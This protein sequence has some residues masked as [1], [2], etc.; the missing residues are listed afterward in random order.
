M[1]IS[2]ESVKRSER[3]AWLR[4]YGTHAPLC[5]FPRRC[6]MAQPDRPLRADAARNRARVLEVAYDTFAAEGLVG[7]DRRDRP[8]RRRRRRAP[9]TGTSRPRRSC[10]GGHRG[11]DRA[12]SSTTAAALLASD[13]PGEA[14]FT[15]LRSMVLQWGGDRSRPGRR[16]RRGRH[17]HRDRA[18]DAEEAFL[19]LLGDLLR[20]GAEGGHGTA[21][22]RRAG[23]E[24]DP[25]RMPGDAGVQPR[26]GRAGDRGRHRRPYVRAALT[27]ADLALA[28]VE[29]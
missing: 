16:A 29:C 7:A 4:L 28:M 8:A 3:S 1:G 23:R 19:D 9:S 15:F 27:L 2:Y 26:R 20:A 17:R 10:S 22:R 14:L 11:P 18:P 13:G 12:T 21:R 25:G 24:G 5:Q 6:E